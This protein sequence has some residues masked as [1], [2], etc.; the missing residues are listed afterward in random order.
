[1]PSSRFPCLS[2]TAYRDWCYSRSFL[3]AGFRPS[4]IDLDSGRTVISFW[5][6]CSPNPESRPSLLLIHG[7]GANAKW[8]W[9]PYLRPLLRAGFDLYVPD[10]LFFGGSATFRSERGEAFQ[11]ECLMAAMKAMGVHRLRAVVGVSYGGFVGYRIAAMFPMAVESVVLICAG[12]CLEEKDL[13]DGM[14]VVDDPVEAASLLV[15]QSP[16]SLRKL[17]RLTHVRPPPALP[18]CFLSDYIHVM[19]TDYVD[20]KTELILALIRDRKLSELPKISQPTLIIWGE[21]DQIFPLELAH[22]LK[23]HLEDN[24]ELVVVKHS[25]H[26]VNLEKPKELCKHLKAFLVDSNQQQYGKHKARNS[27]STATEVI[28]S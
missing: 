17:I 14:F 22:R 21:Q 12:V 24:S 10:L 7:F 2:F 18:S 1:M 5:S 27:S 6:P 25:G 28:L 8:Q 9:A 16:E 20:E 26:A 3:S 11:A 19:C 15:P 23:R 13:R 4:T